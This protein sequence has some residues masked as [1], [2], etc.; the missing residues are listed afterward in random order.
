MPIKVQIH[1]SDVLGIFLSSPGQDHDPNKI[2]QQL[3]Y[4]ES[5]QG[6]E[7]KNEAV[8]QIM[9][10]CGQ[11]VERGKIEDTISQILSGTLKG[12]EA[13]CK[14]GAGKGYGVEKTECDHGDEQ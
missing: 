7:I 13:L 3:G 4:S 10:I 5:R 8:G 11:L 2:V 12:G 1:S 6:S 9:R 14:P